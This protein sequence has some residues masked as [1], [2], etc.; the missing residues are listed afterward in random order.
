MSCSVYIICQE[1]G[2]SPV[3]IGISV[4][5]DS[6][7]STLQ[8]AN[9]NRLQVYKTFPYRTVTLAQKVE[10]RVHSL[11]KERRIRGEWFDVSP[12]E[13]EKAI[14]DIGSKTDMR[15][16]P[17]EHRILGDQEYRLLE[18]IGQHAE[19]NGAM[20]DLRKASTDL[21]IPYAMIAPLLSSL[22]AK[23]YISMDIDG[24][25]NISALDIFP[26]HN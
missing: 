16:T 8:A 17:K 3:K 19:K 10:R 11:L 9:P 2:Q 5:V 25:G 22:R 13:A 1:G 20:P 21:L 23:G 7:F 6:R 26:I 24:G 4:K 14:L 18:F 15:H 12:E